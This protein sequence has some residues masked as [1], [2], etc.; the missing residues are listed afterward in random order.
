[1]MDVD[2]AW[3]IEEGDP[4]Y[5]IAIIDTGIDTDHLEFIDRISPLSFNAR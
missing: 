3:N 2:L 5:L 4:N 1:M